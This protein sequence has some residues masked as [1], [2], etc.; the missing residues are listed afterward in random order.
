MK[1]PEPRSNAAATRRKREPR[2]RRVPLGERPCPQESCSGFMFQCCHRKRFSGA[3]HGGHDFV[4]MRRIPFLWQISAN[5]RGVA[6]GRHAAPR[7]APTTGSKMKAAALRIRVLTDGLRDRRRKPVGM[8]KSFFERCSGS[9]NKGADGVPPAEAARAFVPVS[10][11]NVRDVAPEE[12]A[13]SRIALGRI[14]PVSATLPFRKNFSPV[15]TG[16]RRRSRRSI[17]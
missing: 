1:A 8:G 10:A 2:R 17:C 5:V 4:R 11:A 13:P 3:A 9:R 7:V 12:H 16:L 15:P 14:A 6:F